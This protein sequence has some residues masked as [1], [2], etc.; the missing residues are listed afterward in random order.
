MRLG[1]EPWM[2]L[3][4]LP[5]LKK[6]IVGIAMIPNLPIQRCSSSVFI[7]ATVSWPSYSPASSSRIGAT[8]R[9]GPHHGAQKST[10]TGTSD[11]S[12]ICSN[13]AS[14]TVIG[15]AMRRTSSIY[16]YAPRCASRRI[17]TGG[18]LCII[19]QICCPSSRRHCA[20]LAR[21]AQPSDAPK[22]LHPKPEMRSVRAGT[23]HASHHPSILSREL[24][25]EGHSWLHSRFVWVR[26][27]EPYYAPPDTF[28]P[29]HLS[30][31]EPPCPR[32][33]CSYEC[34]NREDRVSRERRV[35]RGLPGAAG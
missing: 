18:M 12:T 11:F 8:A 28:T 3:T 1:A 2:R 20:I 27:W 32:R 22:N 10:T 31:Y 33:N 13:S 7:L 9:Q 29:N 17:P 16:L 30:S 34:T 4:S 5:P 21:A 35:R 26:V 6:I 23:L 25:S 24:V 14:V 15:S 19:P